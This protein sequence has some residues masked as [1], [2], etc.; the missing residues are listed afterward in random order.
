MAE[1]GTLKP[2]KSPQKATTHIQPQGKQRVD[3]IFCTLR[4]KWSQDSSGG[5]VTFYRLDGPGLNP[6]GGEIFRTCPDQL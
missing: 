6:G 2:H 1:G 4:I 5:T 3:F